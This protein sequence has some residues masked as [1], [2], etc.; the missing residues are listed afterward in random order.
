MPDAAA[1]SRIRAHSLAVACTPHAGCAAPP[2]SGSRHRPGSRERRHH[3]P[4]GSTKLSLCAYNISDIIRRAV[5]LE[6]VTLVHAFSVYIQT[7]LHPVPSGVTASTRRTYQLTSPNT[8]QRPPKPFSMPRQSPCRRLDKVSNPLYNSQEIGEERPIS[9]TV[10]T[11]YAR[12]KIAHHYNWH[13]P[14]AGI[15]GLQPISRSGLDV[16]N[17]MRLHI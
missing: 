13:R 8:T 7:I 15:K 5:P 12:V 3:P 1:S 6:C 11:V 17:L 10:L 2:A 4:Q 14:H 16:N 9:V